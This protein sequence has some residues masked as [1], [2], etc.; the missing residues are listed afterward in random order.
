MLFLRKKKRVHAAPGRGPVPRPA[1]EPS[2]PSD[3][4]SVGEEIPDLLLD[5]R[6]FS[7][8]NFIGE[9]IDGYLEPVALLTKKAAAALK[10]ASG[11]AVKR[12]YRLKVFDAY[13]PQAAV[14]HFISWAKDPLDTRMQAVFYPGVDK[15]QLIPRG[16]IA[17]RSSHSRGSAVDLTLFD[18]AA[19][20]EAD[21]GGSFDFFGEISRPDYPELTPR[22]RENRMLLR[23]IMTDAGFVPL[24]EEWWHFTLAGEP[25]PDTYFTFPVTREILPR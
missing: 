5:I 8:F 21:M 7:S 1:P 11:E 22:Q 14:S 3:F 12:G 24:A 25:Y 16:F 17:E 9:R 4:V 23:E 6:Y 15:A 2:D 18:V 10:T 13:R 20:Q 19:G